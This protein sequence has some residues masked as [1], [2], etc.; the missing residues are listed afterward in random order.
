MGVMIIS[1]QFSDFAMFLLFGQKI[2]ASDCRECSTG[3]AESAFL[4]IRDALETLKHLMFEDPF[5]QFFPRM[6]DQNM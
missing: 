5:M 4:S 3:I 1:L 6:R 2:W